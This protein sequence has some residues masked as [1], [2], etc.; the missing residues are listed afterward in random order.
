L[1]TGL[2]ENLE[3]VTTNNSSAIA[4]SKLCSLLQHV[5]CHLNLLS[6]SVVAFW[7]YG[8]QLWGTASTS[9]IKILERFQSKAFRMIMEEYWFVPNTVI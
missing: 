1:V 4:N 3:I 5:R 6:S 8:I 7:T 2:T 9:N